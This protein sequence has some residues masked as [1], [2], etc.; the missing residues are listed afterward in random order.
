VLGLAL[1]PKEIADAQ[2]QAKVD[3]ATEDDFVGGAAIVVRVVCTGEGVRPDL[4]LIPRHLEYVLAQKRL[5]TKLTVNHF[6]EISM[7]AK[8]NMGAETRWWVDFGGRDERW[9]MDDGGLMC[10]CRSEYVGKETITCRSE[11]LYS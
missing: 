7:V 4:V 3:Q 8:V 6:D 5:T 2:T 11:C 9:T 10:E 1:R